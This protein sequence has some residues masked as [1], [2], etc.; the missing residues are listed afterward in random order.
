MN[1][2]QVTRMLC[3]S[4]RFVRDHL[5]RVTDIDKHEIKDTTNAVV[6]WQIPKE[7]LTH[8][9]M[10][11]LF[12]VNGILR[13]A[14]SENTDPTTHLTII[15]YTHRLGDYLIESTVFPEFITIKLQ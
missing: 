7:V 12:T 1:I 15:K 14:R 11:R 3:P 6:G 10:V 5:A 13:V 9:D 8:E 4:T 2:N